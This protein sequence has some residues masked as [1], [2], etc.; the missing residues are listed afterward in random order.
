MDSKRENRIW[1][2]LILKKIRQ[3]T[4]S[5]PGNFYRNFDSKK[6]PAERRVSLCQ[7]NRCSGHSAPQPAEQTQRRTEQPHSRGYWYKN[8][9]EVCFYRR[10]KRL[11]VSRHG[12]N[13]VGEPTVDRNLPILEYDGSSVGGNLDRGKYI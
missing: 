3:L 9:L 7:K 4:W 5:D 10:I 12:E 11:P 8:A 2:G 1:F 13:I 6:D